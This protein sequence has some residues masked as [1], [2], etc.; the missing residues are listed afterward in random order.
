MPIAAIGTEAQAVTLVAGWLAAA[1]SWVALAGVA[2]EYDAD[3]SAVPTVPQAIIDVAGGAEM[4]R[5]DVRGF[6]GEV[7]VE[8]EMIWP[9]TTD[10][11][12]STP[13]DL[14]RWARNTYAAIRLDLLDRANGPQII[15]VSGD[16][17]MRLDESAM[18]PLWW[19]STLSLTLY[20]LP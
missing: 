20:C 10:P 16:A 5:Q 13:A 3:S 2:Y 6:S 9:D 7:V 1:P 19:R 11:E 12:A 17:P 18:P 8:V 4:Q 15:S 14:V